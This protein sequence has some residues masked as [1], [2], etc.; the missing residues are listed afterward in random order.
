MHPSIVDRGRHE[1]SSCR[2]RFCIHRRARNT[3]DTLLIW[4]F[5]IN[6][7]NI[8]RSSIPAVCRD[9]AQ[10]TLAI[11]RSPNR[12]LARSTCRF[13]VF[14]LGGN[15]LS[16]IKTLEPP[17][18]TAGKGKERERKRERKTSSEISSRAFPS[19]SLSLSFFSGRQK[20]GALFYN[21]TFSKYSELF[22]L[23]LSLSLSLFLSP[24]LLNKERIFDEEPQR[25]IYTAPRR[26]GARVNT[27]N[28]SFY[29]RAMF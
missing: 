12:R 15:D 22:S 3:S 8:S 27:K 24:S 17:K 20:S 9:R 11:R 23:S 21:A 18:T 2:A 16:E 1:S 14:G 13:F 25:Q 5:S 10:S 26:E 6:Y 28:R 4:G 29:G 7:I 19:L